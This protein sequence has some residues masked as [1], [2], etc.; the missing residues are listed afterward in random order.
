M[1]AILEARDL[2]KRYRLGTTVVDALRGVSLQVA[3]GEFVALMGPSGSGKST[4]L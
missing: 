4:L 3:E 2:T 1:P